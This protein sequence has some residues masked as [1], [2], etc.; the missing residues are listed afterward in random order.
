MVIPDMIRHR[1]ILFP[2]T[3][4]TAMCSRSAWTCGD[5]QLYDNSGSKVIVRYVNMTV[6]FFFFFCKWRMRIVHAGI[7][8]PHPDE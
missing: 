7:F 5:M 3:P 4:S 8:N 6:F 1:C 2:Y